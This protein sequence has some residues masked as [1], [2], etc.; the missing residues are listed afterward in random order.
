MLAILVA[1]TA[2]APAG[3]HRMIVDIRG[4]LALV[5]VQRSVAPERRGEE[6]VLD[7]ALPEGARLLS[8]DLGGRPLRPGTDDQVRP[9]YRTAISVVGATSTSL[10]LD[11]G[12]DLRIRIAA[13]EREA[14]PVVRYRFVAPLGCRQGRF[15]LAM[16]G[17]REPAP[18]PA[19][20]TV[21]S[22]TLLPRLT[23]AGAPA[24][25]LRG[26]A[27]ARAP[28]EIAF[29][30]R[31]WPV[32]ARFAGTAVSLC[33]RVPEGPGEVPARVLLLVD[34][35]R[36]VG[37]AGLSAERDLA[38]ALIQAL[39]PSLKFNVL[40][41]E[42]EVVPLF[43][44]AR[45][46]TGETLGALDD[47]T[48]PVHLR[49]GSDFVGV[50]RRAAQAHE[51]DPV[52]RG[53]TWLVV[54]TDGSLPDGL[55][56]QAML[57]AAGPLRDA[58]IAV[59]VVRPRDDEP[60][61]P[62]DLA[63]LRELAA[64]TGGVL[65]VVEPADIAQ[66]AAE[67]ARTMQDGGD[68]FWGD[69]S[70]PP[71]AG[72]FRGDG[73]S[74]TARFEGRP[75]DLGSPREAVDRRWLEALGRSPRGLWFGAAGPVAALIEPGPVPAPPEAV[76]RGELERGVVRNA[77]SLT[78]TP[79][80]RA[81]YLGRRVHQA[82]DFDLRGRLKLQLHLERGEMVDAVVRDSTLQ[83]PEL[84]ACL[85]EAAFAV[86]VPRPMRKDAPTIAVLNLVFQPS[87]PVA[88]ADASSLGREIDLMLGPISFPAD[89]RDLLE[90]LRSPAAVP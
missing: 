61:S 85:R 36:S 81:C 23:I 33:R 42:R 7:V 18:L 74:L 11:E 82:G 4:A 65:R 64:S 45:E 50:F 9:A 34:R 58:R 37:P 14:D 30:T 59:A 10:H 16:P 70:F 22:R 57:A 38:R 75:Q 73:N 66:T 21:S 49:N 15:V 27:P 12:T 90:A 78:F 86:E 51:R 53:R 28:W 24:V 17:S 54:I 83:R 71:G 6:R 60:T 56:A 20:V 32:D 1:L 76:V 5:E 69:R 41:F 47:A 29:E 55:E 87:T 46:A 84:E 31:H 77:L 40:F 43:P 72:A 80:A 79:R 63:V 19:Q 68:L 67:I 48:A 39:P 35:S 52:E 88:G 3:A 25:R 62:A 44:I 26:S 89:G 2:V 13:P 8:A